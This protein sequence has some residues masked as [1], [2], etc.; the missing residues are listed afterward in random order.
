MA[1]GWNDVYLFHEDGTL[2]FH[3]NQM[4][5]DNR[6]LS[7]HGTWSF[8]GSG[9]DTIKVLIDR[10]RRLVGG[11]KTRS[12]GSC[13]TDYMIEGGQVITDTLARREGRLLKLRD[14][15]FDEEFEKEFMWIGGVRFWKFSR[16]PD[17]Y[18]K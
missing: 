6:E 10:K 9:G 15:R 11:Y 14:Y 16:D 17:D 3:R 5:C 2:A 1:S 4:L 12:A 8:H 18:Y 7:E 13:A